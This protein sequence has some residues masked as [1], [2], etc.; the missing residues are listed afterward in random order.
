APTV[1]KKCC[2]NFRMRR[3][4]RDN[5]ATSYL[6]SPECSHQ[7]VIFRLRNGKE[8]CAPANRDWVKKYQQRLP[9]SSFSI[10]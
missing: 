5:I 8:V 10:P 6:T 9:F 2:F 3:I 1:P 7:A 4:M